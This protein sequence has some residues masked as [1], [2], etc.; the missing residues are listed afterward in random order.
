MMR[1]A[2]ILATFSLFLFGSCEKCKRCSY[3]YTETVIIQG[4]NG[5]EEQVTEKT[6]VL[7]G[8]E[9]D[10]FNEECIKKDESFT[11]EQWYQGKADTTMLDNF[12]FICEDV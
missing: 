12:D 3:T 5:E 6:G 9:G 8:P 1:P 7:E 4:V 10:L 2:F 11:I